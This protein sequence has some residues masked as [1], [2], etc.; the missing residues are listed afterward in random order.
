[1]TAA[2]PMIAALRV[3]ERRHPEWWVA[4]LAVATWVVLLITQLGHGHGLGG[5][6]WTDPA[7]RLLLLAAMVVAM[8]APLVLP[9]VRRL[10][11]ASLRSRRYRAG[12]FFLAGFV[13]A[14]IVVVVVTDGLVLVGSGV[15]GGPVTVVLVFA[16]A[17]AWQYGEPKRRALRRCAMTVPTALRGWR[18]DRDC[19]RFGALVA[20]GCVGTCWAIMAAAATA[21]HGVA[22]MAALGA[23]ALHERRSAHYDP[24]VGAGVL[25]VLGVV[26]L[27]SG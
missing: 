4:A 23:V 24:D 15:L 11:H 10:A 14:W 12:A 13:A 3:A 6:L 19:V 20:V 21:G 27:I 22:A 26:L 5:P 9:T 2:Q 8:M 17:A 1:M 7:A 16:G 25:V 18:A